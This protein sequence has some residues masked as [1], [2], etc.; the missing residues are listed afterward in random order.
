MSL[1]EDN[2]IFA[3]LG[4][5]AREAALLTQLDAAL[6]GSFMRNAERSVRRSW[7]KISLPLDEPFSV[8]V[9]QE[10]FLFS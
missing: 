9:L 7:E 2:L 5:D 3:S 6:A 8:F 1:S 10:Y 4:G